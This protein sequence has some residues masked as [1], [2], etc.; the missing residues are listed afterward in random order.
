MSYVKLALY[1]VGLFGSIG[2]WLPIFNIQRDFFQQ[3]SLYFL[4]P[5]WLALI[6]LLIIKRYENQ[7][8]E[9]EML[10]GSAS[11]KR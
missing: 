3:Y 6:G 4:V 8:T 9:K 1:I 5:L 10:R 7:K 2:I 11:D